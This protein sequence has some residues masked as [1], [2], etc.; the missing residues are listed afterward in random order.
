MFSKGAN[1]NMNKSSQTMYQSNP[2]NLKLVGGI[3]KMD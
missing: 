3:R 1:S 2:F